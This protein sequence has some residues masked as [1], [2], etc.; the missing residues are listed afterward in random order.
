MK[1]NRD[2]IL[3]L[4]VIGLVALILGIGTR[5]ALLDDGR[6]KGTANWSMFAV[7]CG[8][9]VLYFLF[10]EIFMPLAS[11]LTKKKPKK[12]I[13][14]EK[15]ND[16]ISQVKPIEEDQLTVVEPI[17]V[18]KNPTVIDLKLESFERYCVEEMTE[19]ITA[20]DLKLLIAYVS[21][22]ARKSADPIKHK[23]STQKIDTYDILHFGWNMWNHFKETKQPEVAKW[24]K[25]VFAELD[26]IDL[27]TI[28][29][30]LKHKER[31][32]NYLIKI[33]EH[34]E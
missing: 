21:S 15:T 14:T 33:V 5:L 24:L 30:N 20:E 10:M 26:D 2:K 8:F 11:R 16:S 6:D 9:I 4:S 3:Q 28:E 31:G 1:V 19:Y 12:E 23:I 32:E 22:Y 18:K 29:H 34:I 7:I 13:V 27:S 25:S 17:P